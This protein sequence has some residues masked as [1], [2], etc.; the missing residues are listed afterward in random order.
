MC[1]PPPLPPLMA[2]LPDMELNNIYMKLVLHLVPIRNIIFFAH[3]CGPF[4]YYG[5]VRDIDDL[6]LT[7]TALGKDPQEYNC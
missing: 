7:L 3:A 5:V 1:A 4:P 6:C 2:L